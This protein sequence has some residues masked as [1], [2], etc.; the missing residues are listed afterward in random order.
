MIL[1]DFGIRMVIFVAN[2][3]KRK[4]VK[5]RKPFQFNIGVIIF[6][7]IFLYLMYFVC[8]YF[9]TEQ[10]SVYE[11]KLGTIAQNTEFQGLILRDETVYYAKDSGYVNYYCRAGSKTG[12]GSYVYSIDE[13]GEFYHKMTVSND[14]QLMLSDES[15]EQLADVADQYLTSYSDYN[16]GQVYQ[17]KYDMEAALIE[18]LNYNASKE[19]S[20]I[21]SGAGNGKLAGLHIYTADAD[22][23]VV[24]YTDGFEDVTTDTFTSSMFETQ[25]YEKE[26][27]LQRETVS[28]G[29]AVYKMIN[30]EYWH[31]VIPIEKELAS[32]L[33]EEENIKVEF[34]K[35]NTTAW[36]VSQIIT[37][38]GSSYLI[39]E[40]KN[41]MIRFAGDRFIELKLLLTDTSGLK[42]PNSAITAKEFLTVPKDYITKGGDSNNNGLLIERT[43][44]N[45]EKSITFIETSLFY[46][47]DEV[48]YI[49][50]DEIGIG[51]AAVRPNSNERYT[52][53]N[54]EKLEGVYNINKGYA[55]FKRIEKL[56][57]NE[58][59]TIIKSGTTYGISLYDH[60]ALNSS[61]IN[62]DDIVH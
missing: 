50:S 42:I 6:I 7:F 5:Y 17:F 48:Y 9:T 60:I 23:V 24:Y 45:G 37:R 53:Q 54:M 16:F 2:K 62:E 8:S 12:A 25:S 38:D 18:A 34:K 33:A 14:G 40:F 3:H 35:D 39:L 41:S 32:D 27:F 30:S 4:I 31:V 49:D 15:Y 56:F 1:V 19:I 43:A 44:Q 47:T 22:G 10:I 21:G 52:L 57:E 13:T 55:V 26:N 46:E 36:A 59:Y 28:T 29:E 58:E 61:A 11:V 51:D 20:S